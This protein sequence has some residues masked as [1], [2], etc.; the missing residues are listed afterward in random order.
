[1]EARVMIEDATVE[2]SFGM[3]MPLLFLAVIATVAT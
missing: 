1:M 2:S 3:L